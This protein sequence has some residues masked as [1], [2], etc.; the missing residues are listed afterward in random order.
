MRTSP[1]CPYFGTC[2]G[3]QLQHLNYPSQLDAKKI[4]IE[5]ALKRIAQVEFPPFSVIA[6]HDQW[7]YRRHIRLKLKKQTH[8]FTAGYTGCDNVSFIEV[9]QCPIFLPASDSAFVTLKPLLEALS[10]EN[11]EEGSLRIIKTSQNKFLLA[12]QFSPVLPKNNSLC[13]K[14]LNET[15][16]GIAMLSF[17]EQKHWGRADC[18]IELM[19]LKARFSPFGFV[20][21]H[22]EQSINLYQAILDALPENSN[23]ILDLYCGIGI[24]SLL[25][26]R[27]GREVIGVESHGETIALANQN[28][29]KNSLRPKFLEGKSES[30]GVQI[31]KHERPNAVLCNP[32][33]TGL[34]QALIKALIEEKPNCLLY[35]SCMPSTLARDL[36]QLIQG[37]YRIQSI[38]GFDMFPQTTHVEVLVKLIPIIKNNV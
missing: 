32:P 28:A 8:G 26:A 17:D 29:E 20:Q 22:P 16:E 25:F 19:G 14:F 36:K 11:I 1:Q 3:C 5:D 10:N 12:F 13:E 34:D 21:N 30:L 33:R 24:T 35:V 38:Q 7:G 18:E 6:A 15:C 27:K 31:L 2:G 9:Q 23:K 37:G 4:F